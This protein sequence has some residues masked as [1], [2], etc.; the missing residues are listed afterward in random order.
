MWS[1]TST[2]MAIS[3]FIFV[4]RGSQRLRGLPG[5]EEFQTAYAAPGPA[6]WPA[7]AA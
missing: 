6:L 7:Q 5:S 4:G 3:A 2:G 1:K